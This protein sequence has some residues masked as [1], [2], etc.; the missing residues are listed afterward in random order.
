[1]AVKKPRVPRTRMGNT[2][3]EAEYWAFIRGILRRGATRY[4]VKFQ[5]KRAARRQSMSANKRLKYEYV[6]AECN[7]W[8]PDKETQVDHLVPCGS[9]KVYEDLPGFVERLFCE[10]EDMQVLCKPCHQIKTNAERAARKIL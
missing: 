5:V 7:E 10:A 9:L 4:A 1:M 3:T 6:C 2:K 8:F